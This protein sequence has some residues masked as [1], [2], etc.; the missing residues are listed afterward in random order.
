MYMESDPLYVESDPLVGESDPLDVFLCF[1]V[2]LGFCLLLDAEPD[3][4][5]I[6]PDPFRFYWF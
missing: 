1:R 6:E 5:N 4:L 2:G 3:P